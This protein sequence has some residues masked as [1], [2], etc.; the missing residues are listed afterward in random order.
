[1]SLPSLIDLSFFLLGFFISNLCVIYYFF[2][3]FRRNWSYFPVSL[4]LILIFY[5]ALCS[6]FVIILIIFV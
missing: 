1:M 5:F 2:D 4:D 3:H 6:L